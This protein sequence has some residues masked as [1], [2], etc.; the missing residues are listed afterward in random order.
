MRGSGTHA[1]LKHGRTDGQ[2]KNISAGRPPVNLG[3][4]AQGAAARGSYLHPSLCQAGHAQTC[5]LRATRSHHSHTAKMARRA[6]AACG[7]GPA[8]GTRGATACYVVEIPAKC[9]TKARRSDHPDGMAG[10]IAPRPVPAHARRRSYSAGRE[11]RHRRSTDSS[12][13]ACVDARGSKAGCRGKGAQTGAQRCERPQQSVDAR[14]GSPDGG[15]RSRKR[16]IR[17]GESRD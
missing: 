3:D 16:G 17:G 13:P 2:D 5:I 14:G 9:A 10:H 4:H 11:S 8:R 12:R 7:A 6:R 15:T 1:R